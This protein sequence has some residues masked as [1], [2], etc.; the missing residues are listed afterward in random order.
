MEWNVCEQYVMQPAFVQQN[1]ES[2][3][4][5]CDLSLPPGPWCLV[6]SLLTPAA[7]GHWYQKHH[8]AKSPPTPW[9]KRDFRERARKLSGSLQWP[10]TVFLPAE[11]SR[12]PK[13]TDWIQISTDTHRW[14]DTTRT[15]AHYSILP[16]VILVHQLFKCNNH[17]VQIAYIYLYYKVSLLELNSRTVTMLPMTVL[18]FIAYTAIPR[19]SCMTFSSSPPG[20]YC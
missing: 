14:E 3:R 15:N 11:R 7:L 2:Y 17:I 19:L 8:K 13:E 6:R 5:S 9:S 1:I 16:K 12:T 18:Y 4:V 20:Q 10:E